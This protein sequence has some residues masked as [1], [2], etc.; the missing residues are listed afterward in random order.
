[1]KRVMCLLLMLLV[2]APVAAQR[3]RK[4][5]N[6]KLTAKDV[7]AIF[8]FEDRSK[9]K[10][11]T[12]GSP[13][14]AGTYWT[15]SLVLYQKDNKGRVWEMRGTK[16]FGSVKVVM[17]DPGQEKIL[18]MGPPIGML[19]SAN[20]GRNA[21]PGIVKF[22]LAAVGRS[23]EGYY[24]GAYLGRKKPPLPTFRITDADGKTL[25]TGQFRMIEQRCG[26]DWRY[27]GGFKGRF[28]IEIKPAM[29]PFEWALKKTGT[30]LVTEPPR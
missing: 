3:R 8:T 10:V 30:Y 16:R 21:P 1:M 15:K 28:D 9:L 2:T 19:V 25:A 20:T 13:L 17:V 4:P 26:Y 29:G 5:A 18:F 11:S 6:V 22:S 23:S 24:P 12:K 27:P 14:R 7:T